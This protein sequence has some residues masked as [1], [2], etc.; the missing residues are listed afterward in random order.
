MTFT[1]RNTG[2]FRAAVLI[3]AIFAMLGVSMAST[4][5]AHFHSRSTSGQCDVC[6]TAHV[7]SV[8]ARAVFQFV[9]AVRVYERLAPG[10]AI[11]GYQLLLTRSS[12]SR[13][14]P[15]LA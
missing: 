15:S 3:V 12:F 14:P 7:V 5:A 8:E 6:V 10:T 11:A 4:S 13:G 2:F 1:Q 9:G